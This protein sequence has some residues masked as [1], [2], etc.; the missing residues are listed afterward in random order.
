MKRAIE[1]HDQGNAHVIPI[2]LR[3]VYWNN[4]PFAKLQILPRDAR[5][6]KDRGWFDID[7]AFNNI[8]KSIYQVVSEL[9]ARHAQI[10]V[11]GYAENQQARVARQPEP[12][13]DVLLA[14]T[15]DPPIGANLTVLRTLKGHA[16]LLSFASRAKHVNRSII[17]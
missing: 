11:D 17:E 16:L 3:P 14:P 12:A 15:F 9:Q 8:A 13:Q 1:R 5:P 6:V 2:L 10:Q 4:A 7:E